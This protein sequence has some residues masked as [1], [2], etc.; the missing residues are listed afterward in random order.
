MRFV[1]TVIV[2]IVFLAVLAG[3]SATQQESAANTTSGAVQKAPV[4][5]TFKTAEE[6]DP[7]DVAAIRDIRNQWIS[8]FAAGNAAP[9]EF[10]FTSDAVF[11]L[12]AHPSLPGNDSAPSAKQVF[13]RFTARLALDEQSEQFVTDGGDPRKMTKLPWVSYYSGYTLTL[14]PKSGGDAIKGSGRFM[15][16]FHRQSDGSLKVIRGPRVGER[17]PDFTLNLMKGGGKVQLSS[18]RSKPT[19]LIFGSY[20]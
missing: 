2:T 1:L 8:A 11:S 19:V 6:F 12:P 13:D 5:E 18:L 10:M 4:R 20:T 9:V 15:T 16:R 17:A 14:T 7:A 3:C